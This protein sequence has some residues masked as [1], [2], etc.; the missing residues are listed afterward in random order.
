MVRRGYQEDFARRCFEQIKGFGS[1]G[2]PES[3]ALSFARL[4]YVSAWIK[5]YQPAVFC[6]ALLNSQPMGFYAPAQIVRDA[7]EHGVNVREICVPMRV[8]GTTGS[9]W[10]LVCQQSASASARSTASRKSW[11]E[12]IEAVI[13][14]A[15]TPFASIEDLA[16][17]ASICPARA[18]QSPWPMPTL[19]RN[20]WGMCGARGC[21]R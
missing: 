4:V 9:R 21:G 6:A 5:Y 7:R 18:L 1:Y 12:A 15:Q 2:F 14:E 3:H 20:R 11:A 13:A 10:I 17:R 8:G 19:L 16:R